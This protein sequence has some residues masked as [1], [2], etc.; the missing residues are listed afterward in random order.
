MKIFEKRKLLNM[1][2]VA[3]LLGVTTRTVATYK[4]RGV[5]PYYQFGRVV[6]FKHEDVV[7]HIESHTLNRKVC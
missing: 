3:S 1:A 7:A 4:Q 5:I 6:R 2:E